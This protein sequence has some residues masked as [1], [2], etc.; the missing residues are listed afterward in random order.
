MDHPSEILAATPGITPAR[1]GRAARYLL[2]G[3]TGFG[4]DL[5]VFT[6]VLGLDPPGGYLLATVV[7]WVTAVSWNFT[8][9]WHWTFG[10]PAGTLHRQYAGY[11]S[12]QVGAFALRTLV[13]VALVKA[14]GLPPV[15][16]TIVGVG[17]AALVGFGASDVLVFET[18]AEA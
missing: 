17:V 2:V 13:V 11:V 14:G 9:N 12:A 7:A 15:G 10:R 16:A 4:V 1:V 6:S 8:L 5:A 18:G 3:A